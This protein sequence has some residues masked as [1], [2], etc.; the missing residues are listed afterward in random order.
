MHEPV[1]LSEVLTFLA[2]Q[3]GESYLDLTA[4]Y[5][6][7]AQAILARTKA[8]EQSVLVDRDIE[9]I[10]T[11]TRVFA[12]KKVTIRHQDFASAV[13]T[14][15]REKRTFDIVLADL[16]TSSPHL[17]N[18][19]R[20]FSFQKEAKLDMRMDR[21]Q[22]LTALTIVNEW[23]EQ[24]IADI[25]YRF[26]EEPKARKIAK[27]IVAHR[28]LSNTTELADI[29][30]RTIKKK[31]KVHPATRT[32]QAIRI[33]VNNELEQLDK[34]LELLPRL[35]AE[36][37]RLG[38]I[39][40]HSLEDRRVKLAFKEMSEMGYESLFQPVTKKPVMPSE[41]EIVFN[42]RSRS[43]KLRVVAKIKIKRKGPDS[44]AY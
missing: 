43:S 3:E 6:G 19:E 37:G 29:I 8:Y 41:T 40:F 20:G 17:D 12:G 23:S 28:P 30:A 16:G 33:A 24:E 11:L 38:I 26:G 44:D 10:T 14:L 36:G 42:P 5:A 9:A 21:S 39:T 34:T 4:G 15:V 18:A 27:A 1:L 25:I 32:F 22:S 7:H 35:V 2:P 13:E 31:S